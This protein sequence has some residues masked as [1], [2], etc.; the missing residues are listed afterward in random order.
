MSDLCD[1]I[2]EEGGTSI[3]H[4]VV[5]HVLHSLR[6]LHSLD[7]QLEWFFLDDV[8]RNPLVTLVTKVLSVAPRIHVTEMRAAIAS[9]QRRMGFAPPKSVVLEFCR[10]ACDCNI[11]GEHLIANSPPSV[12]EVLSKNELL[13]YSVLADKGPLLHRADFEQRCLERGMNRIT[14]SIYLKRA[15]ILARYGPAV[16]GLRGAPIVPGDVERCIP[17]RMQRL[18]DHGWTTNAM[19]WL[20]VEL[21][22]ASLS[23]GV[24][25]VPPGIQR[26]IA[27][28][29][30][31]RM[32]D[33]SE[34]GTLVVSDHAA[35]GL[36]PLFRRRGGESGDVVVLTFDLQRHE[37]AVR[38][39]TKE[40]VFT[41]AEGLGTMPALG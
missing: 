20:A 15:P 40:E 6:S 13:T 3:G 32:L 38:V 28:R 16:Y 14:F 17:P 26:F 39:G 22:P 35:W 9:D 1:Q 30:L 18:R 24:I 41:S 10:T 34:V 12:T 37:A 29:H 36:G 19:P 25:A 8:P 33:G 31:L 11:E 23:S 21:S 27:G 5:K 2:Q 4:A 7:E